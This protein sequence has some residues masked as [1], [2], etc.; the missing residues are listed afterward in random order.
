MIVEI[1]SDD[2]YLMIS[3]IQHYAFCPRQ[4]ALIHIEQQWKEN[5]LTTEGNDV[6]E[7]VDD[8]NFDETRKDKRIVRRM[9]LLSEEYR[10][11]GF[12]DVVEFKRVDLD[13]P[14]TVK[15]EG[16]DGCWL[17]KPIEY[18][19]GK[20]KSDDRDALQLC[21]QAMC[22]EEMMHVE[23]TVGEIYYNEIRRREKIELTTRLRERV[24]EVIGHMRELYDSAH[25][26]KAVYKNHCKSCSLF[27]LCKPKWS[28][29]HARSAAYYVK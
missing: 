12:A 16:R 9:P 26:P 20:P 13:T 2:D 22:L 8:D 25:T 23:I 10:I 6:H 24:I 27:T 28:Q 14:G 15:L 19:R 7:R 21:A 4:W 18:K 11:R 1:E 5:V 17:V 29:D 3:G